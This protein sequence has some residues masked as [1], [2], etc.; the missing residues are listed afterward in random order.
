ML[1]GCELRPIR[2]FTP[3]FSDDLPILQE[4]VFKEL[5]TDQQYLYKICHAIQ[6]GK[7]DTSLANMKPGPMVFSRFVT[8]ACRVLRYY[9]STDRPSRKLIALASFVVQVY[10][11]MWFNIKSEDSIATSPKHLFEY[12]KLTRENTEKTIQNIVFSVIERNSYFAHAENVLLT[13]LVDENRTIREQAV[14]AIL[15]RRALPGENSNTNRIFIKPKL[16]FNAKNYYEMC[17]ID[18]FEPPMTKNLSDESL[19]L[20]IENNG[21]ITDRSAGFPCHTQCVERII[22]LVSKTSSQ[23]FGEKNRNQRIQATIES[24]AILPVA[25]TKKHYAEYMKK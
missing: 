18:D 25:R 12:I 11:P 17:S 2:P 16:N 1:V 8:T 7:V 19:K 10:G 9:V 13:M 14:T 15:K 5:S 23:V 6:S 22:Q 3:I 4:E 20:C 24:R 21:S